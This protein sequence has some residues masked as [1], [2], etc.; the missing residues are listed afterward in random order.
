[1]SVRRHRSVK[2]TGVASP[3][4]HFHAKQPRHSNAPSPF[5]SFTTTSNPSLLYTFPSLLSHSSSNTITS[6]Y[7]KNLSKS[8]PKPITIMSDQTRT[9]GA[10]YGGGGTYGSS[11]GGAGSYGGGGSY[12]SSYGHGSSYDPNVN[13][14]VRQTIKFMTAS[15][16]GVSFLLLSGLILTG[17]VI[18]VIADKARDVKERAKD[19][20][21]TGRTQEGTQGY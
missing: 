10:S 3:A 21:G 8:P 11:Y 14:P 7:L 9:G 12:G 5:A 15:T 17:T 20:A 6:S 4:P 19:Y 1:M 2:G 18:G 13:Q 16:I